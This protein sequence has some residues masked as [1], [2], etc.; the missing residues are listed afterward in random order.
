MAGKWLYDAGLPWEKKKH[1]W[2]N[3]YAGVKRERSGVPVSR[4]PRGIG[5]ARAQELLNEGIAIVQGDGGD[6]PPWRIYN[7]LDGVPYETRG[8][9]PYHAFP[10][11]ASE[12]AKLPDRVRTQLEAR[13]GGKENL[14]EW[15]EY[16]SDPSNW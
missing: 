16:S 12:Y 2:S 1:G 7:V 3:D 9:G 8:H 5:L 15:L 14:R 13:A 10:M 11:F 4:C 6:R